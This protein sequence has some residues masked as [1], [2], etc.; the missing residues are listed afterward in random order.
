[1]MDGGS[2]L[3]DS[4]DKPRG[5]T[6][7]TAFTS[8]DTHPLLLDKILA[9]RYGINWLIW[10]PETLWD[11]MT[12]DFHLK[13]EISKHARSG[14]QAVKTIHCNDSFFQ[15]WQTTLWC[16]QALDGEPPDFDVLQ[17]TSP[18]QIWHAF[19][20][21]RLLRGSM[22]YDE[23]VQSWMAAYWLDDGIVYAPPPLDFMQDNICQMEAICP[24]CDNV[25]WAV[26][27]TECPKCGNPRDQL[28]I[29]PKYEF[30]DVQER[31]ELL[32]G[33]D[34]AE[35]VLRED[36][37]GVQIH[38]LFIAREHMRLGIETLNRQ[39]KDLGYATVPRP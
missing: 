14:I 6:R 13:M 9:D 30:A 23:E 12:V 17:D 8:P 39:L 31:W 4:T 28:K 1:M 5:L 7:P 25:E 33:M 20:C 29:T 35:V 36:R 26:G 34:P 15:D 10:E 21:A 32:K 27:L 24:K 22:P 2:A 38:K 16:S 19:E 11:T 37:I 18:G 3:Q